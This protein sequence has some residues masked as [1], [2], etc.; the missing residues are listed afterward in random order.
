MFFE[1]LWALILGFVLSGMV[2]AFVSKEQMR[3]R[4]GDHRPRSVL[5]A[6]GYGMVSSSCSYAA[7]AN[8]PATTPQTHNPTIDSA[9][10]A[11]RPSTNR[12]TA[13]HPRSPRGGR[14]PDDGI[15]SS[16]RTGR[17]SGLHASA[18]RF[19]SWERRRS[20]NAGF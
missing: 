5:R 12:A 8:A 9:L 13:P 15:E 11:D 4:L 6:A 19:K 18:L 2:Q 17:S 3:S 10:V 7:S 16:E 20:A 1:T 14:C